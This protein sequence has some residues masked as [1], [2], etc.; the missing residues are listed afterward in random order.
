M[1]PTKRDFCSICLPDEGLIFF[2]NSRTVGTAETLILHAIIFDDSICFLMLLQLD[3]L[4]KVRDSFCFG[5]NYEQ[6]LA[7]SKLNYED[8]LST[9]ICILRNKLLSRFSIS[10]CLSKSLSCLSHYLLLFQ[11]L[12]LV[13]FPFLLTSI[14]LPTQ[15]S[16]SNYILILR[17]S[18]R[19]QLLLQS[20]D[21]KDIY[22]IGFPN[23]L[24]RSVSA[25]T[26]NSLQVT[27]YASLMED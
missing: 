5:R 22:R 6:E 8:K 26:C 13:T 17:R 16:P 2:L 1:N 21:L 20:I 4:E 11:D 27:W 3:M 25:M 19:H 7:L 24:C 12:C 15:P 14:G 18:K 10:N 9:F 23:H